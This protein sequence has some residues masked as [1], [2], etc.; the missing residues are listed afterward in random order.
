MILY[1]IYFTASSIVERRL[2]ALYNCIVLIRSLGLLQV[3]PDS[4]SE[5][6]S[7][8]LEFL[9]KTLWGRGVLVVLGLVF[10]VLVLC[11]LVLSNSVASGR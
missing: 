3:V 7:H 10:L 11:V 2:C 4:L 8:S 1:C 6:W 9:S 5:R